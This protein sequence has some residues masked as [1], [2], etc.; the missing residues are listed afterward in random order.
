MNQSKLKNA[1][2]QEEIKRPLKSKNIQ[3]GLTDCTQKSK[4]RRWIMRLRLWTIILISPIAVMEV[5]I[6]VFYNFGDVTK[7]DLPQAQKGEIN[8]I[9]TLPPVRFSQ[10]IPVT[11]EF[12]RA[13]DGAENKIPTAPL[14]K[15]LEKAIVREFAPVIVHEVGWKPAEDVPV[16]IMF[17]GDE[18]P[19]NNKINF[20]RQTALRPSVYGELTAETADSYY[21]TY[22]IYHIS[23]YDHPYREALFSSTFHEHDLEG[24]HIRIDKKQL[25][26]VEAE[27]WFH[28]RF[29]YCGSLSS[30]KHSGRWGRPFFYL[31]LH[32]NRHPLIFV[33][34]GGHGVR[35]AQK[36]DFIRLKRKFVFIPSAQSKLPVVRKQD[37]LE[38]RVFPYE[39][40]DTD[41]FLK[42]IFS[43]K[44]FEK[45]IKFSLN[46]RQFHL[47]RFLAA[48]DKNKFAMARPKPPWAWD[49]FW[50]NQPVGEWY[51]NPA[52]SFARH[53]KI[54]YP[55]ARDLSLSYT[56][57]YSISKIF[58]PDGLSG[59]R[60]K[61][62][63]KLTANAGIFTSS[64]S[65]DKEYPFF[66]TL[67]K[68]TDKLSVH[69]ALVA[70]Y[71]EKMSLPCF[72]MKFFRRYVNFLFLSVGSS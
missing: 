19:T 68:G 62:T 8:R 41:L 26:P 7:I 20:D 71:C 45:S 43:K 18:D 4:K 42:N 59:A 9:F 50:D 67:Q 15:D 25:V 48:G 66:R 28:N 69:P 5:I 34:K 52:L 44:F 11:D 2:L 64:E 30:E 23:D 10:F 6:Y 63:N 16:S 38:E 39:L 32:R 21:L 72:F 36:R 53:R 33:L 55:S 12:S 29:F 22:I 24:F 31:N 54:Y 47:G 35:C 17:D 27:T 49:G 65:V 37:F 56:C 40:E 57:H 58:Q 70:G 1:K 51:F 3:I 14:S 13:T 46:R 60:C 61:K